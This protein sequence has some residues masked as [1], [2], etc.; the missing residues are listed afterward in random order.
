MPMKRLMAGRSG[1]TD[2][3]IGILWLKFYKKTTLLAEK[4]RGLVSNLLRIVSDRRREERSHPAAI[5]ASE[6]DW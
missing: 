2:F 1:G 3:H 4:Y 5:I 6:P